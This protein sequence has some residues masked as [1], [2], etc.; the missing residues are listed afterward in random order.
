MYTQYKIREDEYYL[1]NAVVTDVQF[2]HLFL[3]CI[4]YDA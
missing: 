2:G 1:G 4:K 3:M